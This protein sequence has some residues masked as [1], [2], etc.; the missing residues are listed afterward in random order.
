MA[1][2][3]LF[4]A[5][6]ITILTRFY[7]KKLYYKFTIILLAYCAFNLCICYDQYYCITAYNCTSN[8][9]QWSNTYRI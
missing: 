7:K 2:K 6:S 8:I 5:S 1:I 4:L 9:L 3:Q